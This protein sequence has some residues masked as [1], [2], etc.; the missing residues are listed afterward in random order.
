MHH[1][2]KADVLWVLTRYGSQRQE[3]RLTASCSRVADGRASQLGDSP[4][5]PDLRFTWALLPAV[6][7]S[8]SDEPGQAQAFPGSFI[9][10]F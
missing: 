6:G 8:F 1:T 4:A 3:Q 7:F 9:G 10:I 5:H 2:V